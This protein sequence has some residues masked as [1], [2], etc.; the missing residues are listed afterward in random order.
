MFASYAS[1]QDMD[2][3]DKRLIKGAL[4][5]AFRQSR[6]M[7][8]VL[9][10]ARVE[11]PPKILK[12]GSVGKKNQVRYRCAI[13]TGLFSSGDIQVDHKNTVIPL[14]LTEIETD[15]CT[16][17]NNIWCKKENLQVVC[18]MKAGQ[19]PGGQR[20]CHYQKTQQENFIRSKWAEY[21]AKNPSDSVHNKNMIADNATIHF[22]LEEYVIVTAKKRAAL[23]AKEA[24][25][26]LRANKKK[27]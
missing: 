21:F 22:W 7:R 19:L 13:C 6:L 26:L 24:R 25:K 20:S 2:I 3:E 23:E 15:N 14:H 27:S 4:R 10:E 18:S 9:Q 11:L 16:I 5:R 12:D 8:E 17:L 1:S